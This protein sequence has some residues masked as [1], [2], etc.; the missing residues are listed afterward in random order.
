[1]WHLDPVL[2]REMPTIKPLFS[3][4]L[5]LIFIL[6]A[7]GLANYVL[8]ATTDMG[9]PVSSIAGAGLPASLPRPRALS[10]YAAAS[11]TDAFQEIGR[12]FEAAHPGVVVNFNFAGSQV[13]RTQLEHGA[14]ADVFASADLT[15]MEWLIADN[16]VAAD[17]D[18]AFVTNRLV[19]IL[20]PGNPAEVDSLVDLARPDLKLILADPSVPAGNYARQ[21]L[22]NL[23]QDPIYGTDFSSIV[24]GH[25]VSNETDVRQ[26][27]TKVELDEADAGI[28]YISD[29]I[30]TPGLITLPIPDK[31]N[32]MAQYPIAI[33]TSSPLPDLAAAFVGY[34][35]SP[36]GQAIMSKWGFT[37]GP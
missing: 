9:T 6:S 13:L 5:I 17:S 22:L 26:V 15:N 19:V 32:V 2:H 23:S 11:L 18:Q 28:V 14:V 1:M 16:L 4:V 34:V 27:V 21:V 36:A 20:P 7:C 35:T 8:P 33:L 29:A 24:L 37:P 25:V 30:A 12:E 10:V 31:F 3:L